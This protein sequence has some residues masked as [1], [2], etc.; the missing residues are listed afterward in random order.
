LALRHPIKQDIFKNHGEFEEDFDMRR[1]T[2]AM[3]VAGMIA[4]SLPFLAEA[5]NAQTPWTW[6][7]FTASACEATVYTASNGSIV[8]YLNIQVFLN[9]TATWIY[10]PNSPVVSALYG[11]CT[12]GG[13]GFYAMAD[14]GGNWTDFYTWPGLK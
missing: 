3:T 11:Q 4:A 7:Q 2:K 14:G 9:G 6:Y 5:A 10:V 13:T 12:G 1:L 8:S